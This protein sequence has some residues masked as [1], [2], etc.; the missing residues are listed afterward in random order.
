MAKELDIAPYN[1]NNRGIMIYLGCFW[2]EDSLRK[3]L[4]KLYPWQE[5][6]YDYKAPNLLP[7]ASPI[8][9]E[10]YYEIKGQECY[11][12]IPKCK[13]AIISLK[14]LELV[15]NGELKEVNNYLLENYFF[16][17]PTLLYI[18]GSEI[19]PNAKIIIRYRDDTIEFSPSISGM[20]GSPVLPN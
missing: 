2:D 1:K 8:S 13:N 11:L 14:E 5:L 6:F 10:S 19:C 12:L 15:E 17:S 20:D 9:G 3:A 7:L 16:T 4:E 18:N